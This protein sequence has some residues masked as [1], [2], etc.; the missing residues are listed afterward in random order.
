[1]NKSVHAG[2]IRG[3]RIGGSLLLC[4]CLIAGSALGAPGQP[5]GDKFGD[6]GAPSGGQLLDEDPVYSRVRRQQIEAGYTAAGGDPVEGI[7]SEGNESFLGPDPAGGSEPVLLWTEEASGFAWTVEVPAAGLYNIAVD[8]HALDGTGDPAQRVLKIDGEI[9]FREAY[10]IAFTRLWKDEG[11]PLINSIG[12]QVR[13]RQ[14]EVRK[15]QSTRLTD[16]Q[17]LYSSP[18]LFYFEAGR[19]VLEMEWVAEPVAIRSVRLV[20]PETTRTYA[21]VKKEYEEKGYSAAGTPLDFQAESAVLYKTDTVIRREYNGDPLTEPAADGERMLNAIGGSRWSDGGQSITWEFYVEREGLYRIDI[22]TG[23]WFTD[24]LP[25]YRSIAVDGGIPFDELREYAFVYGADWRLETLSGRD[26]EPFL[27]YFGAGSHTIT[28]KAVL[29]PVTDMIQE[30]NDDSVLLSDMYRKIIMLTGVDPDPN[31]EYDLHKSIPGLLDAFA[32]IRDS[33]GRMADQLTSIAEKRPSAANNFI[34]IQD[35]LNKL[36]KRPDNISR[37]L[38]DLQ[39]A[40]SNMGNYIISLQN[41]PLL[42][43]YIH[44]S[45]PDREN[46]RV[47]SNILEKAWSTVKNFV[48]S[49]T[50]D[51]NNIAALYEADENNPT[52]DVWIGRGTEWAEIIKQLCD[53]DFTPRHHINVNMNILPAGQLSTGSVNA[54]LL[55]IASGNAPDVSMGV[56]PGSPVEFA[57]RGAVRNLREFDDYERVFSRFIPNILVPFE[58]DGGVY[59]I[60]EQMDFSVMFYRRDILAE[61]GLDVPETWTDVYERTLPIL[62]QNGLQFAPAGFSTFIFQLGGQ[63]YTDDGLRTALDSPVAYQ[64]FKEWTEQY[65]SYGMPIEYNFFNRFRTGEMPIGIANYGMYVQIATA[66]PELYGRWDIAMVPGHVREDGVIDRSIGNIADTCS[67]ILS[68]TALADEAFTFLDWWTSTDVQVQFGRELEALLGTGARWNTANV[69]AFGRLPWDRAHRDVILE[70]M[71]WGKEIPVV[72][73]GYFTSRHLNNA[74][75]RVV[76]SGMNIPIVNKKRAR[77]S[78]RDSLDQAVKDINRELMAKQEEYAAA[79]Q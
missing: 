1:M 51:Y 18:F 26:G 79:A 24:G 72:L 55:A 62:N 60:P 36:I 22:R 56:A 75:N 44:L 57:I 14:I 67:V 68:Q 43:D 50:K 73:G 52:I 37:S 27:F 5:L 9:P 66:A 17:G 11:E 13:P 28:M 21:E 58:Y 53:E 64:A 30:I 46:G 70:Q 29:G 54:I 3:F 2:M 47:R 74:W 34:T 41:T 63:Y 49:F 7:L 38:S 65:T 76:M 4:L 59:A 33:M 20:P 6:T 77:V 15:W 16:D 25:V 40:L 23:Q 31:Y 19:H 32:S 39:N 10:T 8:Y 71:E 48:R 69:E 61:L 12:D 35:Q 45:P 78:A 42:F